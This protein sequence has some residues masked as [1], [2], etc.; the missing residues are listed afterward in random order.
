MRTFFLTILISWSALHSAGQTFNNRYNFPI[1][2]YGGGVSVEESDDSYFIFSNFGDSL[3]KYSIHSLSIDGDVIQA[4]NYSQDSVALFN[5]YSNSSDAYSGGVISAGSINYGSGI[6]QGQF[7]KW[8]TEGDTLATKRIEA[9]GNFTR[10]ILQQ[11]K[12]V[13]DGFIAVGSIAGDLNTERI[14]VVK[15]DFQLNEVWR[16]QYGSSITPHAGYSIVQTPDGGYLIGGARKINDTWDHCIIKTTENGSQQFIKYFGNEFKCYYAMVANSSDGNFYFGGRLQVEE[17]YH[18]YSQVCKLD[19]QLDTIW[20][21]VY[22]NVGAD[23]RVNSLK[24]LPDGNLIACGSDRSTGIMHGYVMKLDP[25]GNELWYRKYLQ[26]DENWCYFQDV[27]QTTDGGYFLTG[28]L[29]PEVGL[30]QD[31]W[32]IKL[33]DMGCLIPGC[34]TAQHVFSTDA[35]VGFSIFPNPTTQFINVYVSSPNPLDHIVFELS[36]LQGRIVKTFSPTLFDTT[37]MIDV[38]DLPT[39]MYVLKMLRDGLTMRS[40]KIVKE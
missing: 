9:N 13:S 8:S 38:Q 36:D 12:A 23:C 24:L 25:E 2:S 30:T 7:I 1:F 17:M 40:E 4:I 27:I 11:A 31:I 22:G 6:K 14:F 21:K 29:F 3:I 10:V 37:Y 28:M 39:G 26:T 16:S 33:D 20:C 35:G 34:D 18:D 19:T 5:G 32:G 15:T